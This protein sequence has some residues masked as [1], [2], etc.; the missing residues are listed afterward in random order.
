MVLPIFRSV[1]LILPS[2][3]VG[4]PCTSSSFSEIHFENSRTFMTPT[5]SLWP[6]SIYEYGRESPRSCGQPRRP[7]RREAGLEQVAAGGGLP[8]QHLAGH[9]NPGKGAEHQRFVDP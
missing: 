6:G 5:A 1:S 8:V 2:P 3:A 7:T 9:E 4:P